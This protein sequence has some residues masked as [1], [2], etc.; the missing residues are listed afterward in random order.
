MCR[1]SI[2]WLV[3]RGARGYSL[4]HE[5]LFKASSAR[6]SATIPKGRAST[7]CRRM[8][9]LGDGV[10]RCC[11]PSVAKLENNLFD[12]KALVKAKF[13]EDGLASRGAAPLLSR[14]EYNLSDV[15]PVQG[16]LWGG[17]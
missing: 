10:S 9:S 2:T 6:T 8:A 13:F 14:L 12:V 15:S 4:R 16:Q 17:C 1:R 3:P 7:W 5:A 11:P